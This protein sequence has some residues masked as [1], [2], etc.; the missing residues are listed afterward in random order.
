MVVN[1]PGI[2]LNINATTVAVIKVIN[3]A[4]LAA[5]AATCSPFFLLFCTDSFVNW[6]AISQNF[7]DDI[8]EL[9]IAPTDS[10]KMYLAVDGVFWYTSNGGLNWTQSGLNLSG[11]QVNSIAVH[12]TEP[13]KIAIAVTNSNKVYVSTNGGLSFTAIPWDLP[14]FS[15]QAV[16]WQNNAEDGLYVGMNYGI[17]YTDN[18]L[19]NTWIPFN[20]GLPNVRINELEINSAD[21]RLYAATYGRGLWRSNLYDASL[22]IEEFDTDDFSIY[23]NPA[24]NE[25]NIKWTKPEIVTLRIYNSLGK[26]MFY[27]KNLEVFNGHKIDVSNFEQGIYF[28]KLNSDYG[29]VTKKLILD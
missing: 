23:P 20:N 26:I 15:A 11:G 10:N 29:E 7:G 14:N 28:V 8:D 25:V 9:K 1:I 24:N 22:S 19:G 18:D 6:T 12:P 5:P 2:K 17:Y 27:A 4:P 21:N 16:A 13:D 3:I